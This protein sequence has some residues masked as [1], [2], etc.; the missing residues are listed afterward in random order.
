MFENKNKKEKSLSIESNNYVMKDQFETDNL[1]TANLKYISSELDPDVPMVQ[2][3]EHR[4]LFEM[5]NEDG[6]IRYR[7]IFT[8]FIADAGECYYFDLPYV[9]NIVFLKEQ[10][11]TI[12]KEVPKYALLLILNDINV[13]KSEKKL[14]R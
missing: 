6:K 9:E 4:Y 8:G 3:T 12:A 7:E 11:P 1:V 5:I 14:K 2:Q 10:V 13:K